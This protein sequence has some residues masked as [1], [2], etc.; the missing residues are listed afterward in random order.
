MNEGYNYNYKGKRYVALVRASSDKDGTTSTEAQL[1]MQHAEGTRLQMVCVGEVILD[2][3]T[4]SMP[5]KR[6][7]LEQLLRRK[8]E[9]DD[10][11]VL[12]I[13]RLDH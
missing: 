5:G 4:G 6:D 9:K 12:V 10:F 2:G 7:D 8:K 11:D 3:V 1:A 13:Q